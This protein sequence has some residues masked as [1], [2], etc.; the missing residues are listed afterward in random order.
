MN[1]KN[2]FT[3][4]ELLVVIAII[5]I[6]AAILFPVFAQA[7]EAAR[8]TQNMSNLKQIGLG[9][10]MYV[11]DYDETMVP[12]SVDAY[13][14]V[15]PPT[16]PDCTV[17]WHGKVTRPQFL[18]ERGKGLLQPYMKSVEIQDDPDGK[19]IPTPF[20]TWINGKEVPAYG[21]NSVLFTQPT[22]TSP[23]SVVLA[24]V[25]EPAATAMLVDAVNAFNPASLSKSFFINPPWSGSPAITDNGPNGFS[26]RMHGRHGGD[27]ACVVWA[28]GHVKA[29]KPIFRPQGSSAKNDARR[30]A[31]IGELSPIALPAAITANDPNLARYN[32]YFALNK[33]TGL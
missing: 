24:Q 8:K 28:D 18:Y 32:Y 19:S 12:Y 22:L 3:L 29:L 9:I 5:A 11:Q 1:R 17:W 6:L 13:E 15:A 16:F 14:K 21:T 30:A 26:S 20:A 2:A 31:N 27:T 10:L 33:D 25:Q 4:I 23:A 7:R